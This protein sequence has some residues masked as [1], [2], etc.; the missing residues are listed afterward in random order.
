LHEDASVV[1]VH[2][3]GVDGAVVA[4]VEDERR[5]RIR[6]HVEVEQAPIGDVAEDVLIA[7]MRSPRLIAGWSMAKVWKTTLLLVFAAFHDD[8]IARAV[9]VRIRVADRDV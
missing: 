1:Q 6:V 3:G 9:V 7:A 5:D 2:A 4:R 8:V